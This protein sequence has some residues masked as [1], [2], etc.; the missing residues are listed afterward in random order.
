MFAS[1]LIG[2]MPRMG[3][4]MALRILSLFA[5]LDVNAQIRTAFP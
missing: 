5:A 3:K 1:M 2:A 4:T